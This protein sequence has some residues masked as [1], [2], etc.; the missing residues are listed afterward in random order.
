MQ[1]DPRE[2]AGKERDE[3]ASDSRTVWWGE[4]GDGAR[5]RPLCGDGGS[6]GRG[7]GEWRAAAPPTGEVGSRSGRLAGGHRLPIGRR[8]AIFHSCGLK[9]DGAL[10]C[11]GANIDGQTDAPSGTFSAVS[12]GG[13]HSCGL[14]T[15][16]HPLTAGVPTTMGRPTRLS[17]QAHSRRLARATPTAAGLRTNGTLACWGANSSGQSTAPSRHLLGR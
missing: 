1:T 4:E 16:E 17:A 2:I 15:D 11:W 10:H 6:G 12:A 8:G 14:K 9:T 7:A 3:H 13:F 5:R